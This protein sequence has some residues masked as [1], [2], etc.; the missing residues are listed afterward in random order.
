MDRLP[1]KVVPGRVR[2]CPDRCDVAHPTR[3]EI[4]CSLPTGHGDR[5]WHLGGQQD[6]RWNPARLVLS[7]W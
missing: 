4:R 7:V 1:V 5:H 6:F 3:Q 2:L